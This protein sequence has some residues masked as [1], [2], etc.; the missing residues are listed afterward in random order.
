MISAFEPLTAASVGLPATRA[1]AAAIPLFLIALLMWRRVLPRLAVCLALTAGATLTS[2]WLHT[3]IT[4]AVGWATDLFNW[5]TR[6]TVGGVVPGAVALLLTLYLVLALAPS[7]R[8]LDQLRGETTRD[9]YDRRDRRRDASGRDR[10][11][12][13]RTGRQRARLGRRTG[14]ALASG[15]MPS[16]PPK[17][18]AVTVALVLP[19]VVDTIPG[20]L[21]AI[22]RSPLN[23]LGGLVSW[24]LAAA[25]GVA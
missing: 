22:V 16:L 2:G 11:D 10:Y 25:W 9:A 20:D 8:T 13:R 1:V 3:A 5:A 21:G 17:T 4:T 24:P 14:L 7:S 19:L 12:R 15:R 18:A 6:S 23:I